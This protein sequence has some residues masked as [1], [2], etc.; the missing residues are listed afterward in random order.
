MRYARE[1]WS[2]VTREGPGWVP[3]VDKCTTLTSRETQEG[4]KEFHAVSAMGLY[5]KI[6]YCTKFLRK[7]L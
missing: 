5:S 6:V 4:T 3:A 7:L 2:W 1:T